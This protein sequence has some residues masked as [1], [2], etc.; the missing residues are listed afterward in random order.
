MLKSGT[1]FNGY[2]LWSEAEISVL[3]QFY[4]D[5]SEISRRIP[6]RTRA[7]I[8][9]KCEVLRI[10]KRGPRRW[11]DEE[12]V[13]LRKSYPTSPTSQAFALFQDRTWVGLRAV[14]YRRRIFKK[15]VPYKICGHQIA[16]SIR[17][18]CFE[19][20]YTIRDLDIMAGSNQYFKDLARPPKNIGLSK[21][22][23][24]VKL[25]GGRITV[26]WSNE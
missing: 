24:A 26:K 1:S 21:L 9:K 3:R 19:L 10:V 25:L 2:P 15:P 12:Y 11:S 20:N 6:Q 16:D 22:A 13:R 4:P 23:I 5:Y 7:A 8:E 18:R 14:L 17:Q